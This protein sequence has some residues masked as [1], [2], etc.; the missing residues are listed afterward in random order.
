MYLSITGATPDNKLAKHQPFVTEADAIQH[1]SI[2][3]GFSIADPGGDQEFWVVDMVA[4]TVTQDSVTETATNLARAWA[5]LR[6]E[7]DS[8]MAAS[9]WRF[10]SDQTPSAGWVNY[11]QDLRDLPDNTQDPANV[12]WP[13]VPS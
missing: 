12:T 1:A 10:M 7:R 6:A 13:T 11:R 2:Y 3:N 5:T 4:K 8:L 9:D